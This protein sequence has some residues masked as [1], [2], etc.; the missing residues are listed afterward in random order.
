MEEFKVGDIVK[1]KNP[2]TT[3]EVLEVLPTK[4]KVRPIDKGFEDIVHV[5]NKNLFKLMGV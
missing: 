3:Y 5:C 2:F 1:S 4:L